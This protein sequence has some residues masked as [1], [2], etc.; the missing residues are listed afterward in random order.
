L[1][2]GPCL[3]A[4]L[5]GPGLHLL[6]LSRPNLRLSGLSGLPWPELRLRGTLAHRHW[7]SHWPLYATVGLNRSWGRDRGGAAAIC[8]VELLPILRRLLPHLKLRIHRREPRFTSRRDLRRTRSNLDASTTA[9]IGN[10]VVDNSSI[11]HHVSAIDV[12]HP[13]DVN[14]RD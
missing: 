1:H 6:R 4:S 8:A 14:P 7:A 12:R 10:P 5:R 2:L 9:V 11:H 3:L 13:S